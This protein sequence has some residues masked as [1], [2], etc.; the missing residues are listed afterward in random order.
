MGNWDQ[1]WNRKVCYI[2]RREPCFWLLNANYLTENAKTNVFRT[3]LEKWP[4]QRLQYIEPNKK[5]DL[6]TAGTNILPIASLHIYFFLIRPFHPYYKKRFLHSEFVPVTV[7]GCIKMAS[8][9]LLLMNRFRTE[10]DKKNIV[11]ITVL[12]LFPRPRWNVQKRRHG[13]RKRHRHL[14]RMRIRCDWC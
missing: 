3:A 7:T 13:M 5:H 12:H 9:K 2:N 10:M 4:K 14:L 11:Q 1:P 8:P 6:Q